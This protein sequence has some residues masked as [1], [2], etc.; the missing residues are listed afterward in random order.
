MAADIF[1]A[2]TID[3]F[4]CRTKTHPNLNIQKARSGLL[5]FASLFESEGTKD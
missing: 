2:V 1:F 5:S 3:I 4:D